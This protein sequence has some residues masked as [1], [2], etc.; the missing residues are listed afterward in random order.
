MA[1]DRERFQQLLEQLEL[2][3]PYNGIAHTDEEAFT[4]AQD[5]GYPLVIR[6]SYVLGGRA[7]EIIRDDAQLARYVKE[8]VKVSG[9]SPRAIR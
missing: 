4:I 6:P 5:V 1:E 2:K 3:Q 7:M 8:A 9:D